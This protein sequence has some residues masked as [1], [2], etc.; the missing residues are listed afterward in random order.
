MIIHTPI[1]LGELIDKISILKIKQKNI[2]EKKKLILI[3]E[4]LIL[5]ESILADLIEDKKIED[6]MNELL[7][8]NSG[9]KVSIYCGT[10]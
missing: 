5:L 10:G 3:N 6:R 8:I 4:E 9:D 1:S 2:K 7:K